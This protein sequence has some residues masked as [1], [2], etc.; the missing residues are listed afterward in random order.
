MFY[1]QTKEWYGKCNESF[2]NRA[3]P[4]A[5]AI[6]GG[7]TAS[8]CHAAT[9]LPYPCQFEVT[10][11]KLKEKSICCMLLLE[12]MFLV[13]CLQQ[14]GLAHESFSLCEIHGCHVGPD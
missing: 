6:K 14:F 2:K 13:K 3:M 4:V 5:H 10:G 7:G 9:S 11:L 8:I 1:K 12:V